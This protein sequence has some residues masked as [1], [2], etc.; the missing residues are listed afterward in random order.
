MQENQGKVR[1]LHCIQPLF[2]LK[3]WQIREANDNWQ[4]QQDTVC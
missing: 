1:Q 4:A 3:K 2:D